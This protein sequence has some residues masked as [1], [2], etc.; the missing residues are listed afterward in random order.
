M[1][2]QH[3]IIDKSHKLVDEWVWLQLIQQTQVRQT[4]NSGAS[5]S[6]DVIVSQ[7]VARTNFECKPLVLEIGVDLGV[8]Q[9]VL[10]HESCKLR[11]SLKHEALNP[12]IVQPESTKN[13]IVDPHASSG[14]SQV[15]FVLRGVECRND[16][17]IF[18]CLD[19]SI[20]AVIA[21]DRQM[22]RHEIIQANGQALRLNLIQAVRC[23]SIDVNASDKLRKR[24][25]LKEQI[26]S[27]V[28]SNEFRVPTE[29]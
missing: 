15:V 1:Y 24:R 26:Q 21:I 10:R 4:A 18:V 25:I 3:C 7:N 14:D 27:N 22:I 13:V 23:V 11:G 17:V 29:V 2:E 6:L 9:I 5:V 16:R 19:Q 28:V 8:Q 12:P 20:P